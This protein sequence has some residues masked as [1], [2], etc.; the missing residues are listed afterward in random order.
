MYI[1]EEGLQRLDRIASREFMDM[2]C[3]SDS[4]NVSLWYR[5]LKGIVLICNNTR[6]NRLD[7]IYIKMGTNNIL[8]EI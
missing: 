3:S 4:E 6:K 2:N 5:I 1:F 8:I 7:T